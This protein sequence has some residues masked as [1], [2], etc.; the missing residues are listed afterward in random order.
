MKYRNAVIRFAPVAT[1]FVAGLSQAAMDVS[2]ATGTI[3]EGLVA[4][5]AIGVAVLAVVDAAAAWKYIR[6]AF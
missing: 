1:L 4:V 3:S 2:S 5:A 6:K